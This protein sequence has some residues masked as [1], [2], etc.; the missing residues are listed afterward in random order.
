[1]C[2]GRNHWIAWLALVACSASFSANAA[3]AA[4]AL[5][6]MLFPRLFGEVIAERA[7]TSE[8]ATATQAAI[9]KGVKDLIPKIPSTGGLLKNAAGAATWAGVAY[10][11]SGDDLTGASDAAS[12]SSDGK[13]STTPDTS[14]T[15]QYS[16]I[17]TVNGI[18][19]YIYANSIE[20]LAQ[21]VTTVRTPQYCS[22][23]SCTLA[24]PTNISSKLYSG[25]SEGYVSWNVVET[26]VNGDKTTTKNL[27][28]HTGFKYDS[29]ASGKTDTSTSTALT[30]LKDS[31]P[32]LAT[33]ASIS[34]VQS[35][36]ASQDL[37]LDKIT[38]LLNNLLTKAATQT[39]Y[40]GISVASNPVTSTELKQAI[41]NITN[42]NQTYNQSN[43]LQPVTNTS[44]TVE[45][46]TLPGEAATSQTDLGDDPAI[47]SPTLENTPTAE[48]ILSPIT[49]SLSFLQDFQVPTR[50]AACPVATFSIYNHDYSIDTQCTL[51]EQNRDLIKILTSFIWAFIAL[52]KLLSA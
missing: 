39:N 29:S 22:T 34:Q 2:L 20:G 19:N 17:E 25:G 42:N 18:Q 36:L 47:D 33:G 1:M 7:A 23:S 9:S 38:K 48:T 14:G 30:T 4:F 26:D 37:D 45:V 15:Y 31:I 10:E 49:G 52:R 5:G 43:V 21:Q 3:P 27:S 16:D 40:Q 32:S 28:L 44:G 6:R 35:Q 51:F 11:L 13:Y 41:T 12:P 50:D 24:S 46:V 8:V